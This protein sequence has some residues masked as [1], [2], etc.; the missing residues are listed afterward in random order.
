MKKAEIKRRKRI[1]PVGA[2]QYGASSSPMIHDLA[3]EEA[4]LESDSRASLDPALAATHLHPIQSHHISGGPIPVDFTEAFRRR[5]SLQPQQNDYAVSR[6]R[7]F[8]ASV[9]DDEPYAHSQNVVVAIRN[10]GGDAANINTAVNENGD[11]TEN[12]NIDPSLSPHDTSPQAV[13]D[14]RRAELQREAE[15]MRRLLLAK[16]REI[17]ELGVREGG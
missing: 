12:E 6:K 10:E 3:D 9:Q 13:Q 2:S 14:S 4:S 5:T 8:S 1:V 17:A 7:S 11:K 15:K 16:E